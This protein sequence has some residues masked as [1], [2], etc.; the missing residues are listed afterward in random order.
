MFRLPSPPVALRQPTPSAPTQLE[1]VNSPSG[2]APYRI[3]TVLVRT[4]GDVSA[5]EILAR[6]RSVDARARY[7]VSTLDEAYSQ[8]HAEARMAAAIISSFAGVAFVIAVAGVFGVMTFLVTNR[9]RE[10]GIRMALG[11]QRTD[12]RRMVVGSSLRLIVMGVTVGA[13]AAAV[14]GRWL[15]SQ[16][17]AVTP[18]DP[19]TYTVV[20][21]TVVATAVAATWHPASRASRVDPA[22]TLWSE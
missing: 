15:E 20:I 4:T 2:R 21:A 3:G 18:T 13:I 8:R 9:T 6:A 14:S 7:R 22:M 1:L 17:F 19:L 5:S 12:V 16:L 11:A 10:I